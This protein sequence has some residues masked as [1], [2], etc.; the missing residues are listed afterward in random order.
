MTAEQEL[1][2]LLISFRYAGH[3]IRLTAKNTV[4]LPGN[5]NLWK[6]CGK[7]QISH[8]FGRIARNY[9]ETV[10]FQKNFHIR[11]LGEITVFFT[12]IL[13]AGG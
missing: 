3:A 1:S 12:V 7:A 9:A 10:P 13:S 6:F 8:S 2:K 4:I 11:K 5:F